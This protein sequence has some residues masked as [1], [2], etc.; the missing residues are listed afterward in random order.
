MTF[1]EITEGISLGLTSP[2]VL[3][4]GL[5]LFIWFGKAKRALRAKN[6]SSTQWLL[7]GVFIGFLGGLGDNI[8]WGLAWTLSYLH[9]EWK[10]PVFA[11]GAMF[12]IFFRQGAG[13]I[14]AYCHLRAAAEHP[15]SGLTVDRLNAIV[16]VTVI[17]GALFW[18]SLSVIRS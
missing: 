14:A 12:N 17:L 2:T 3:L 16:L 15:G 5:L 4:A 7:L 6:R 13:A 11:S 18:I 1:L 8:F 10:E 9:H